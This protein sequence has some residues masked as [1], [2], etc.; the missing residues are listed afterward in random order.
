MFGDVPNEKV[1]SFFGVPARFSR[2]FGID[3]LSIV[4][5]NQSIKL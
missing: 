5:D 3:I 1:T 2:S 4:I